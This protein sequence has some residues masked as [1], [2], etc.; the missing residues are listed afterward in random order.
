LRRCSREAVVEGPSG[1]RKSE[2]RCQRGTQKANFENE[3]TQAQAFYTGYID[4]S[5]AQVDRITARAEF[6]QKAAGAVGAAYTAIL[7]FSLALGT[8]GANPL[9]ARVILPTIFLG[10]AIVLSAAYL[11]YLT[12]PG[13]TQESLAGGTLDSR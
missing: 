11:A 3:Y 9:P 12:K 8:T 4:V 10:F 13:V 2:S 5:K 7:A 6:I 1:S